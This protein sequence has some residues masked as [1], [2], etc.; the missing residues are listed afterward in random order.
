M[1]VWLLFLPLFDV[2]RCKSPPPGQA[3]LFKGEE[4]DGGGGTEGSRE[5]G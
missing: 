3:V 4:E 5:T 1:E 2:N